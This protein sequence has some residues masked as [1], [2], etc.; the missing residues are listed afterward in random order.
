MAPILPDGT[1]VAMIA[2][3]AFG[4]PVFADLTIARGRD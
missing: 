3:R 2:N 4:V 1:D